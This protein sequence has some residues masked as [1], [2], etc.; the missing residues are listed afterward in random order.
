MTANVAGTAEEGKFFRFTPNRN[1]CKISKDVT[2]ISYG[3]KKNWNSERFWFNKN[4]ETNS[5]T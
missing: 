5:Y 3:Q 2:Y 4:T 1:S